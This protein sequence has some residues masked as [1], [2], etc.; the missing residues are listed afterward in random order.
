MNGQAITPIRRGRGRELPLTFDGAKES[1]AAS[2]GLFEADGPAPVNR[3]S[4]QCSAT[5]P[6]GASAFM[7]VLCLNPSPTEVQFQCRALVNGSVVPITAIRSPAGSR[8]PAR[9][10]RELPLKPWVFFRFEVPP[11]K[12]QV[13]VLLQRDGPHPGPFSVQAGWWLWTEEPLRKA[14]LTMEFG[15]PLPAAPAN[16]LPFSSSPESERQV[17]VLQPLKAF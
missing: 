15:A 2:G 16:P 11:G 7:Y 14:T 3:L 13:A 10:L 5:I 9:T 17:L 8:I 6:Q 12:S 1:C 4:G